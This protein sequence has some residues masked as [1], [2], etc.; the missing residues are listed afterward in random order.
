MPLNPFRDNRTCDRLFGRLA[1][2]WPEA[3]RQVPRRQLIRFNNATHPRAFP[4]SEVS[5]P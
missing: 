5:R 4:T 3:E 1:V 2:S